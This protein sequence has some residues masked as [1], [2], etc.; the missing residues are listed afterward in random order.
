MTKMTVYD[1]GSPSD[2]FALVGKWLMEH[3]ETGTRV[4]TPTNLAIIEEL[5]DKDPVEAEWHRGYQECL[6]DIQDDLR[7]FLAKTFPDVVQ[8]KTTEKVE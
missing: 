1:I 3:L 4:I 5:K 7:H 6:D 2:G 8:T